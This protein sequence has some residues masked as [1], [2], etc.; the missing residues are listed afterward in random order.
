MPTPGLRR[1]LTAGDGRAGPA[2]RA[3]RRDAGLRCPGFERPAEPAGRCLWGSSGGFVHRLTIPSSVIPQ[4]PR[5]GPAADGQTPIRPAARRDRF[6]RPP[7]IRRP[8]RFQGLRRTV[9]RSAR[10]GAFR[11]RCRLEAGAIHSRARPT[12]AERRCVGVIVEGDGQSTLVGEPVAEIKILPTIDLVR[13]LDAAGPPIRPAPQIR[14][15]SRDAPPRALMRPG[16]LR[17]VHRYPGRLEQDRPGR[18]SNSRCFRARRPTPVGA[19]FRQFQ[20]RSVRP[21]RLAWL[22]SYGQSNECGSERD[23]GTRRKPIFGISDSTGRP[24][25]AS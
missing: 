4:L 6:C 18:A 9:D 12:L 7:P 16:L 1:L 20:S 3:P 11:G 17:S 22:E 8:L 5:T 25:L 19:W 21:L 10:R 24:R 14:R 23:G 13:A 15:R 2:P